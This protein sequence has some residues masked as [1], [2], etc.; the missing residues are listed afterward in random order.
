MS[1]EMVYMLF[2][3]KKSIVLIGLILFV[4]S[5]SNDADVINQLCKKVGQPPVKNFDTLTQ[6]SLNQ[7]YTK[8]VNSCQNSQISK[9]KVAYNFANLAKIYLVNDLNVAAYQLFQSALEIHPNHFAWHYLSGIAQERMGN[10][11]GAIIQYNLAH[12]IKPQNIPTLIRIAENYKI[13]N[14]NEKTRKTVKKILTLDPKNAIAS[15]LKSQLLIEEGQYSEAEILLKQLIKKYPK[16]NKLNYVLANALRLQ[17]RTDAIAKVVN[18]AGDQAL[19]LNDPLLEDLQKLVTGAGGYLVLANKA[20]K[21]GDLSV[22]KTHLLAAIKIE[23]ENVS[24]LHNLGYIS[25]VEGNHKAAM[26]YLKKALENS[27]TNIDIASDYATALVS[28]KK[29]QEA[30]DTYKSILLINP[31]DNE[32]KS[33][34]IKIE[35]FIKS[36]N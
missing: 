14:N 15:L 27:P 26:D 32:A 33:R 17:G 7:A 10:L 36:Q 29:Y 11:D 21:S 18:S 23:P 13:L 20:R 4:T 22:A 6:K 25:G 31:N 9:T 19:L 12:K 30:I 1:Q 16:A 2:H 8:L 34:I 35:K 24:A 3:N 5:C 28:M